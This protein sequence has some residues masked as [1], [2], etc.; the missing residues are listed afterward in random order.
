MI[1]LFLINYEFKKNKYKKLI[2]I[3]SCLALAM[4]LFP[5]QTF[6]EELSQKDSYS[7]ATSISKLMEIKSNIFGMARSV[8][9]SEPTLNNK[10]T[11]LTNIFTNTYD[12]YSS[13]LVETLQEFINLSDVISVYSEHYDDYVETP[14]D[15]DEVVEMIN[16]LITEQNRKIK[17]I[18]GQNETSKLQIMCKKFSDDIHTVEQDKSINKK[19]IVQI[20]EEIEDLRADIKW[21]TSIQTNNIIQSAI[22]GS[23]LISSL[24]I[25]IPAGIVTA[26]TTAPLWAVVVPTTIGAAGGSIGIITGG[27]TAKDASDKIKTMQ[28]K[29][30]RKYDLLTK[31]E[32]E[33]VKYEILS[34]QLNSISE[35]VENISLSL[36]DFLQ[37]NEELEKYIPEKISTNLDTFNKESERRKLENFNSRVFKIKTDS[38]KALDILKQL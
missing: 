24:I 2:W 34:A 35:I 11:D 26:G 17:T 18:L 27:L 20:Q 30:E 1:K 14:Q 31:T 33:V 7:V 3:I 13:K 32:Q 12:R 37:I 19:S 10:K 28:A 38:E 21:F 23:I 16:N 36:L 15:Y 25:G 22:S 6:A 9:I 5:I 8:E 4:S 29:L